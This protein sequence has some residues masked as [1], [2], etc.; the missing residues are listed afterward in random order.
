MFL[1]INAH[2]SF[3]LINEVWGGNPARYVRNVTTLEKLEVY[4][5][6]SQNT[7]AEVHRDEFYLPSMSHA[8][9]EEAGHENVA[10]YKPGFGVNGEEEWL[11][12]RE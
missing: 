9:A 11:K 3:I 8:I 12:D 5:H 1:V 2:S 7:L 6:N 4:K 10:W